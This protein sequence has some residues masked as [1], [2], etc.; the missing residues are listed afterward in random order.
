MN[1][2]GILALI[3]SAG[4]ALALS[5][6]AIQTPAMAKPKNG[7]ACFY[8][9]MANGFSAPNDRTVYVRAGVRDVYELKLFAPCIDVDW[10]QHIA[11]RSRSGDFI[12]EGNNVDYEVFSPS[13]IGRQRCQVTSVRK[14][15]PVEV[16]AMPKKDRP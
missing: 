9:R 2:S 11:L 5:G 10:A 3:T 6:L 7:D 12:C 16:A 1:K 15:T 4:A 13:P 8:G 14:L